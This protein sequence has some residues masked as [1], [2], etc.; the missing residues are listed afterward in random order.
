MQTYFWSTWPTQSQQVLI[1][2]FG[3]LHIFYCPSIRPS[4]KSIENNCGTGQVDNLWLYFVFDPRGLPQARPVEITIFSP[5]D[6]PRFS[7]SSKY[8]RWTDCGIGRVDHWWLLSCIFHIL[9][10]CD[11]SSWTCQ[12]SSHF[13]QDKNQAKKEEEKMISEKNMSRI[14][15][16]KTCAL[17][18][19]HSARPTV[20]Q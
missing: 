9:P 15:R 6:Q 19:I 1:N 11:Y 14:K 17:S 13:H 12:S 8:Y 10:R 20:P 4:S 3:F 5:S 7:K 18:M 2:C 16:Y